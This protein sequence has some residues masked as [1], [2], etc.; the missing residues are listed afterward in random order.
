MPGVTT[1]TQFGIAAVVL[2]CLIGSSVGWRLV[3]GKLVILFLLA[4]VRALLYSERLA[5]L[6]LAIP[7]L[8][9]YFA[10]PVSWTRHRGLRAPCSP[11]TLG[12][13]RV[14]I[15]RV[16]QFRILSLLVYLL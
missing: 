9:L 12:R 10:E 6:E 5:F 8:V 7:L 4:L 15:H 16:H 3:R 13:G 11:R 14:R 1:C 2:G